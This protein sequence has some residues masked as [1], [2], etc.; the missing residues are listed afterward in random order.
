[1]EEVKFLFDNQ[2]ISEVE[3]IIKKSKYELLLISPF[4]DLDPRIQDALKSKI[5]KKDFQLKVL[6]GKN[7]HNIYKSIKKDSL[8]FLKSF[9]NVEIRYNDRLHAKFYRNDYDYVMTSLNLYDYSLANN[10]EV[11][12]KNNFAAKG[13]LRRF[14]RYIGRSIDQLFEK[15]ERDVFGSDKDVNPIEKFNAIFNNS[16]LK[17]KTDPIIDKKEGIKGVFGATELK[18]KKVNTDELTQPLSENITKS[19]NTPQTQNK[20]VNIEKKK[21]KTSSITKLAKSIGVQPKDITMSM[22][23]AGY[24]KDN[25]ITNLGLS[26]GLIEKQYMGKTYIAYPEDLEEITKL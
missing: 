22:E 16:E 24:I 10:I 19:K 2:L 8:N 20:T 5:N 7:E 11:G 23:K 6:F 21:R 3:S 18:G 26:K 12:V 1:M 14:F 9:P 4:I 13:F 15:I 25:G 17:Y